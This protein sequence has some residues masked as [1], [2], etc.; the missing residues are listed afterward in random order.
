MQG[1]IVGRERASLRVLPAAL[2][3]LSVNSQVSAL[4]GP[5]PLG[6]P[7][8]LK[9]HRFAPELALGLRAGTPV[10]LW[11]LAEALLAT[12]RMPWHRRLACMPRASREQ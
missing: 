3:V 4:N 8:N 2:E 10:P 7:T 11:P 9:L 5:S 1:P 6:G 12:M